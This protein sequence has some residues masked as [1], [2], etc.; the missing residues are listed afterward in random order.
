MIEAAG[1]VGVAVAT[2]TGVG[3]LCR[4]GMGKEVFDGEA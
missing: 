3:C 2:W 1:F 4:E